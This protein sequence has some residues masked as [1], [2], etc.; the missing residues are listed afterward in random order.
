ME[1]PRR[2]LRQGAGPHVQVPRLPG[3]RR[4]RHRAGR[5]LARWP[6][7]TSTSRD[8]ALGKLTSRQFTIERHFICLWIGG[9]SHKGRPASTWSSTARSSTASP[10]RTT[11]GWPRKPGRARSF[12]GKDA[13]L[14]IVDA[15]T[16]PWGNIGVGQIVFTDRSRGTVAFEALPDFGTMALALLGP[17]EHASVDGVL[18]RRNRSSASWAAT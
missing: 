3:R 9:G 15:Q 12:Q 8:D 10:D 5:Q 18:A 6:G 13:V 17:A 2:C 11:T 16:G 1:S 7:K 4:R 14:E